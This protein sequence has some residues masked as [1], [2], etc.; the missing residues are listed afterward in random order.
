MKVD[1]PNAT[2][3]IIALQK[4]MATSKK[5]LSSTISIAALSTLA[6]A[7]VVLGIA[8]R[9]KWFDA[10]SAVA[11][12]STTPS[13]S[14]AVTPVDLGRDDLLC[15]LRKM[16][17]DVDAIKM[18]KG[19][20]VPRIRYLW[21]TK[22]WKYG[23]NPHCPRTDGSKPS[24]MSDDEARRYLNGYI[25]VK[26][27][28]KDDI[29]AA[30]N[31]YVSKG[32]AEGRI[33]PPPSDPFLG[34]IVSLQNER[35]TKYCGAKGL[36]S[37]VSCAQSE[38]TDKELFQV[39]S[40]DTGVMALKNVGTRKYCSFDKDLGLVC[41]KDT[42]GDSET[43]PF[44]LLGQ[45]RVMFQNKEAARWC[46]YAKN[47]TRIM[48][49]NPTEGM[50]FIYQKRKPDAGIT[51]NS[52]KQEVKP[53][54]EATAMTTTDSSLVTDP[55]RK[56]NIENIILTRINF[57][58]DAVTA[59]TTAETDAKTAFTNIKSVAEVQRRQMLGVSDAQQKAARALKDAETSKP[60]KSAKEM[61]LLITMSKIRREVAVKLRSIYNGKVRPAAEKALS[62]N[63]ALRRKRME[64]EGARDAVMQIQAAN[65]KS[66]KEIHLQNVLKAV[67][68]ANEARDA[69]K[70]ELTTI[71]DLEKAILGHQT[72][73]NESLAVADSEANAVLAVYNKPTSTIVSTNPMLIEISNATATA[74]EEA[75][76]AAKAAQ[77]ELRKAFTASGNAGNLRAAA[78]AA[79][80]GAK[81]FLKE[82]Q[83][84]LTKTYTPPLTTTQYDAQQKRITLLNNRVTE[85]ARLAALVT[86]AAKDAR[87][88]YNAAREQQQKAEAASKTAR[89]AKIANDLSFNSLHRD[90]A[91]NEA[92]AAKNALTLVQAELAKALAAEI[93]AADNRQKIKV[94][95]DKSK[96]DAAKLPTIEENRKA[97]AAAAGKTSTISANSE[98][99]PKPEAAGGTA[100]PPRAK[101]RQISANAETVPKP[102]AAGGTAAAA[103]GKTS[104]DFCKFRN[105]PKAGS[106]GWHCGRRRGQNVDNF[107]KFRNCPK[108]GSGGWHCGGKGGR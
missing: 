77:E 98:T 97:A 69:A 57:A 19:V 78:D 59:A 40:V 79:L 101:R 82:E 55:A 74:V 13:A 10:L 76:N 25:D 73:A 38:L 64:A 17:T 46:G 26:E 22:W 18:N 91:T 83:K 52:S 58:N 43:F 60:P 89:D 37:E 62:A 71:L 48:C 44:K 66:S 100:A 107:C 1:A 54:S 102:E 75:A 70:A 108:A 34:K 4:I 15:L 21:Y 35:S 11:A 88:A 92:A 33:I 16:G 87:T 85:I 32:H 29:V 5:K 7:G 12:T 81:R 39:E 20:D 24:A 65:M 104:T 3:K 95:N 53:S 30:R 45:H 68:A 86:A 80:T 63:T 2:E 84:L 90:R 61:S 67:D 9:L 105:C 36:A 50:V 23:K 41:N 8:W 96:E 99:V 106:G 72:E 103:A 42:R 31:H 6:V 93:V 49:N 94:Y 27:M 14:D 56:L 47:S 51:F 28:F